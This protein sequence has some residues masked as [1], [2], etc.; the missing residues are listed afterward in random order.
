MVTFA[1]S[2]L[3][4]SSVKS[5]FPEPASMIHEQ[6]EN[7]SLEFRDKVRLMQVK[8]EGKNAEKTTKLDF[9]PSR[10][11]KQKFTLPFPLLPSD[12]YLVHWTAMG[13]DGHKMSGKF[14]FNLTLEIKDAK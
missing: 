3:G 10:D 13:S 7:L 14:D 9:K 8:L 6:P 4:H 1:T 11:A 5:S 12:D 2:A